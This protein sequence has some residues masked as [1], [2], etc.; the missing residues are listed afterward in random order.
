MARLRKGE[1]PTARPVLLKALR[2][3]LVARGGHRLLVDLEKPAADALREIMD[4]TDPALTKKDAVSMALIG[5]AA[6]MV[7][8]KS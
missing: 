4:S 6:K 1:K 2:E 5:F 8:P 7:K 3:G